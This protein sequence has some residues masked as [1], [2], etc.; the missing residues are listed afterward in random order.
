M[1]LVRYQKGKI[2]NF[3]T[4]KTSNEYI[5]ASVNCVIIGSGNGLAPCWRQAI[6]YHWTLLKTKVR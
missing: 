6:I 2:M 4:M 5:Y 3:G 1:I